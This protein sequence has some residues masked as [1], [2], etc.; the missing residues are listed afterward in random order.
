MTNNVCQITLMREARVAKILV[1]CKVE[2]SQISH[3]LANTQ[4]GNSN[5]QIQHSKLIATM[6]ATTKKI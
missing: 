3:E 6:I 2:I 1:G 4:I 5:R